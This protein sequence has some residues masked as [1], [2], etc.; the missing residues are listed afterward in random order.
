MLERYTPTKNKVKLMSIGHVVYM[1]MLI[2][3]GEA[4]VPDPPPNLAVNQTKA[5]EELREATTDVANN[6][7]EAHQGKDHHADCVSA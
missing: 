2:F 1:F 7:G 6:V 3:V 4:A 5:T